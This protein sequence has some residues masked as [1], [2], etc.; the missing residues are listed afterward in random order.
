MGGGKRERKKV[1]RRGDK[2]EETN[3]KAGEIIVQASQAQKGA[4]RQWS[5]GKRQALWP[6]LSEGVCLMGLGSPHPPLPAGNEIAVMIS[7]VAGYQHVG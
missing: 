1:A 4:K 3:C 5:E 2:S 6:E 7:L